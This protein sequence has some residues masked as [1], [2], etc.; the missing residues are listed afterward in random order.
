[1]VFTKIFIVKTIKIGRPRWA[2]H[3]VRTEETR[4]PRQLLYGKPE[5]HRNRGSPK[6]RWLDGL[7][8]DLK[9]IGF[10]N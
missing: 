5:G 3:V 7:E 6:L 2:R 4:M 9:V 10:K 1:M 8:Y